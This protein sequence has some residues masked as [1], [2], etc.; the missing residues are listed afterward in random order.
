[1][2]VEFLKGKKSDYEELV[3]F[4]NYVFSHNGGKTDFPSILPK[5]YKKEYD[6]M[7]NHYI[8]KEDGKIKAVVGVFPMEL[9]VLDKKLKVGGIGTVSVHPYSRGS[10]YMKEL[11]N[12]ALKDMKKQ[13][14][15]FSCLGGMKQRYEYFSYTPCGQKI[16]FTINNEN[17]RHKLSNYINDKITFNEIKENDIEIL[18]KAYH[19]YNKYSYKFKREKTMFLDILKSWGFKVYSIMD[20]D[21]FVGY[22]VVSDDKKYIS[23]LVVSYEKMYLEVIANYINH[24]NVKEV[25]I[26][27]PIWERENISNLFDISEESTINNCYQFNIINYEKTLEALLRFKRSYS[28]LENGRMTINIKEY[29]S[30]EIVIDNYNITIN[31]FDGECDIEL[32]H[33]KAMQLIF[34]P[35]SSF[36]LND[37]K[38]NKVIKS[39]FPV[40][41]FISTQDKI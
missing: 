7:E 21:N 9:M 31:S 38:V 36:I 26:E 13:G 34:S 24:N 1:M 14:F 25:N 23:E 8:V 35:F 28:K 40:P 10:G 12:M 5:L 17:I 22:I 11:M 27:L 3:D 30:I 20:N 32:N 19:L 15:A 2:K 39:W 18:E 33:L 41:L 4:A 37:E 29:G 16:N 6:T